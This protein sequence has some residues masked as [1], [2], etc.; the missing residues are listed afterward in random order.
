MPHVSSYGNVYSLRAT[1]RSDGYYLR[2]VTN[3]NI[4]QN[5]TGFKG[6]VFP[7]ISLEWRLPLLKLSKKRSYNLEP[8][9]QG[10]ISPEGKN[11]ELIPN[12]D[13]RDFEFDYSNLFMQKRL[14]GYDRVEGGKRI[15]YG[16]RWSVY[17]E[18]GNFLELLLG[19][20]YRFT[21]E[22]IFTEESGLGEK[23]SDYVGYIKYNLNEYL[24]LS[25]RFRLKKS[26][27][28][29]QRSEIAA[30]GGTKIF[31]LGA[32]YIFIKQSDP[33][34]PEFGDR[35]ELYAY[36]DT[37]LTKA[38][39]LS[40]THREDLSPGGGSIRTSMGITYE[41]ECFIFGIDIAEDNTEDRDFQSGFS[42]MLRFTLKTIGEVRL[43]SSV[44]VGQ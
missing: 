40:G 9:I 1:L 28:S 2:D 44:G 33:L 25:Y 13:S 11:S 24:D 41:D 14:S 12:E 36:F 3:E 29:P 32:N 31:Q 19:Q 30:S 22:K 27:L 23:F 10:I 6:R 16:G 39:R 20:S 26:N 5:F 8:I 43:S 42:V 38:W 21:K 34:T 35:K 17:G 4:N 18:N 15:N 7:E 37:R